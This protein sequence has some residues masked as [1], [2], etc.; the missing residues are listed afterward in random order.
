MLDRF[1][2][3]VF[4]SVYI[5]SPSITKM[6]KFRLT[7]FTAFT[8][9]K[10]NVWRLMKHITLQLFFSDFFDSVKEFFRLVSGK[11]GKTT[12]VALRR[13][14]ECLDCHPRVHQ[15]VSACHIFKGDLG[16]LRERCSLRFYT[17]K[18]RHLMQTICIFQTILQEMSSVNQRSPL[19]RVQDNA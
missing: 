19:A 2:F 9:V 12:G 8:D 4:L 14:L 11:C 1:A 18:Y 5:F 6:P 13:A 7:H 3:E 16:L 17:S 10:E 15:A